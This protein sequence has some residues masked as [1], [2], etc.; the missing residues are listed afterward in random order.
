MQE[1]LCRWHFK[2]HQLRRKRYAIFLQQ[3][4]YSPSSGQLSWAAAILIAQ[5]AI[6]CACTHCCRKLAALHIL[7]Q[8]RGKMSD[9]LQH[10]LLHNWA[11]K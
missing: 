4:P 5:F 10:P 2:I 7:L 6:R 3:R 8:P 11:F 9:N 1:L